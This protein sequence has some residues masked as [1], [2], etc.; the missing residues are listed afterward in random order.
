[1]ELMQ[2]ASDLGIAV[3]SFTLDG[4]IHRF[5]KGLNEWYVGWESPI[6]CLD[7]GDW[8]KPNSKKSFREN[9]KVTRQEAA[10]I[11]DRQAQAIKMAMELRKKLNKEAAEKAKAELATA[12]KIGRH[13]YLEKKKVGAFGI[14]FKGDDILI[15]TKDISGHVHGFQR[16]TKD[17]QKFFQKD[18][19]TKGMMHKIEGSHDCIYIVEGYATGASIHMATGCAVFC[20]FNAGN[21]VAVALS[22][23]E[24]FSEAPIVIAGDDDLKTDGNPGRTKA[25]EAANA[26]GSATIYPK[27]PE[28]N[29]GTDWNDIHCTMGLDEV[30]NQV[31]E[32][33]GS[34]ILYK[35]LGRKADTYFFYS[36]KERSL[37]KFSSFQSQQFYGL[38]PKHH[39]ELK[40]PSPRGRESTVNWDEAKSYMIEVCKK[41]TFDETRIRG[42]GVWEDKG[43]IVL[44]TGK[45]IICNGTKIQASRFSS[46]FVYVDS[47]RQI[48]Y[49]NENVLSSENG[50]I[51]AEACKRFKWSDPRSGIYL[52]GWLAIARIAG[53]LPIRP[54]IWLTGGAGTGKSTLLE[55]LIQAILGSHKERLYLN[56]GTT[57]AGIR[58]QLSSDAVP[59]IFDEFETLNEGS[60]NR[61]ET[62]MD[63][64][65]Q[66]WSQGHSAI[67]KG[68]ADGTATAYQVAFCALV[69][70]I[71]VSLTND[72]DRSRFTIIEL[73]KHDGD[74]ERWKSIRDVLELISDDFSVG[75]MTRAI[76]MAPTLIEN[77][78]RFKSIL[79]SQL[80]MGQRYG[81][82]HGM[83]LA[84]YAML[85]Q[86]DA[87][88]EVDAKALVM[89]MDDK[90]LQ[91]DREDQ[92][93]DH[94][95]CIQW[96]LTYKVK[97]DK[98]AESWSAE[99]P[100]V[101]TK[102]GCEMQIVDIIKQGDLDRLEVL[103]NYGIHVDDKYLYVLATHNGLSQ[104]YRGT[105]WA[106]SWSKSLKRIEG[107]K[108]NV[109]T[110]FLKKNAKGTKI[111]LSSI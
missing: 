72:A 1:M 46:D 69:S 66:S 104:I 14:L 6:I 74:E 18:Q 55:R 49:D 101:Q 110:W 57:E 86:D 19:V 84:G 106:N 77:F 38:A 107:A 89:S 64:F 60:K 21:L 51:I 26:S 105:R 92:V 85:T 24:K 53:A 71:R 81:D 29:E 96:L 83:L 109:Q 3:E 12:N 42:C 23:R 87:I 88:S 90:R 76:K 11:K 63:L 78:R 47:A 97:V 73:D 15:P 99:N 67:V 61:I 93:T 98:V 37:R 111:P 95:E 35:A 91:E 31:A 80:A 34:E 56:N 33:D 10:F 17:G 36:Y 52:A 5:G 103:R 58:Q 45:T 68:S 28:G 48:R 59:V 94:D 7:A 4:Q 75:L 20:A 16:I 44:N 32:T 54:H 108:S 79:G 43:R 13:P 65:R 82:Q 8:S 2:W 41:E 40:F 39:W 70:S 27:F 50:R 9:K 100:E 30:R 62:I 25:D 22:V 102:G